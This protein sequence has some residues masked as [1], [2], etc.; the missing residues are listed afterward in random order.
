M[1]VD[2]PTLRRNFYRL[3][4]QPFASEVLIPAFRE[5]VEVRGVFGWF[6]A[7]WIARLAP[8]LAVYLQR[9]DTRAVEMTIS[10][11]LFESERQVVE[12]AVLLSD[13]EAGCRVS[14]VFKHGRSDIDALANHALD[15]LGW[16]L[17]TD[18]LRLRIAVPVPS[19]NF[20]PKMWGFGD[21]RDFVVAWGS[22]NA[23]GRGVAGGVEHMEVAVSWDDGDEDYFESVRGALDDWLNGCSLG[24]DRVLDLPQAVKEQIIETA[25]DT[26]PTESDYL[27]AVAVDG[28]PTWAVDPSQELR[29]RFERSMAGPPPR[30]AIPS[31]LEWQDGA[32]AHQGEAVAAWELDERGILEMATGSGKTLTALICA[33][34]LQDRNPDRALLVVVSAPSR[35]LVMQWSSEI[36]GFGLRAVTPSLEA[37][38]G[39]ALS[40]ALRQLRR[41]ATVAIVVTNVML[42]DPAFQATMSQE[43]VET[44]RLLIAD[45]AHGLGADGFVRN[46]PVFF[47]KRLALTATPIRQYDPDGTEEIFDFFG[48]PV[49]SFGLDKAIG[50]CL[51]PYRYYVHATALG[52]D[53]LDDYVALTKRIGVAIA[54]DDPERRDALLIRRRRIIE[55]AESKLALLRAVLETRGPK[56][57]SHAL[58]YA[59]A[60]DP[61][62]Y[63]RIEQLLTDLQIRWAGI[64]HEASPSAIEQAF[65]A[66]AEG[67]LQMLLAKKILDEGIDIP[68]IREAFIVASSTV[69]REW[70]QRRGRVLRK[71]EAKRY[72]VIHDFLVLPTGG[73]ATQ[74]PSVES[75]VASELGRAYAFAQCADNPSG[76]TGVF[77][78]IA[79]IRA[80]KLGSGHL[81]AAFPERTDRSEALRVAPGTPRGP[82]W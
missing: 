6:S 59:S 16:M 29:R 67:N 12:Q 44:D 28:G 19:S 79:D 61:T 51:V 7:S 23:T 13:E 58:V 35:A 3:P 48:R 80:G 70:I 75:M 68:S 78:N 41:G 4:E 31:A 66:F 76:Y 22:G 20:H 82:L 11:V 36:A 73:G 8:G 26:A 60:K 37:D 71:Q 69:E 42:C 32:Y 55:T 14:Q 56:D 15:C 30:L 18:R 74:V 72:A 45:E 2:V 54:Q 50:F 21:D 81:G 38:P 34:R 49:Y 5:A 46:K 43:T 33:T 47:E 1:L 25:P 64:T 24:I 57:L 77:Q 65:S 53:E 39:S 52:Q 62:Q 10:P 27:L 9:S 63:K 40:G 17:A